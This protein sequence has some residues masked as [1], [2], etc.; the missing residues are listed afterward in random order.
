MPKDNFFSQINCDRCGKKLTARICSWFNTET[1][2]M[3]CSAKEDEIKK[4]LRQQ[5][6][7]PSDFEGCG[8]IPNEIEHCPKCGK[9]MCFQRDTEDMPHEYDV[10]HECGK[11]I[12]IECSKTIDETPYCP[13]CFSMVKK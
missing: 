3:D 2:C 6:K 7:N 1:I 9:T 10:C 8:Y 11:H 4:T 5:G 12:C 13:D